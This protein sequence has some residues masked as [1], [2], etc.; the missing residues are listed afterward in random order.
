MTD[1]NLLD[2]EGNVKKTIATDLNSAVGV[3][4]S[5]SGYIPLKADVALHTDASVTVS[6]YIGNL[7]RLTREIKV[8]ETKNINLITGEKLT[9]RHERG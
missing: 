2:P 4:L 6:I 8:G 1:V 9:I 5:D 7:T 3:V